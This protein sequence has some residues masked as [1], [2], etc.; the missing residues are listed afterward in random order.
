MIRLTHVKLW[1]KTMARPSFPTGA[2]LTALTLGTALPSGMSYAE[3]LSPYL[4]QAQA[5]GP[6]INQV[7]P[8]TLV[9]DAAD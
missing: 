9:I 4:L 7:V 6:S 1:I 5:N 8:G 3:G 2:G